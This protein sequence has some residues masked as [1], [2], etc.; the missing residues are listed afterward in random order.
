[1][2]FIDQRDRDNRRTQRKLKIVFSSF[3]VFIILVC[4]I[5]YNQR[6]DAILARNEAQ[7][8]EAKAVKQSYIAIQ[9]KQIA[10]DAIN[11]LTYDMVDDLKAIPRTLPIVCKIYEKTFH[12]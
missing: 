3:F 11:T 6:N 9:Q 1:M 2:A 12:I 4:C 10:L 8:M 5:F 7:K